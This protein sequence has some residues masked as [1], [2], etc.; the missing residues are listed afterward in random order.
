MSAPSR[1]GAPRS[2]ARTSARP[3]TTAGQRPAARRATTP[4][5]GSVRTSGAR[6]SQARP[7]GP[8]GP[9]RT[10]AQ[11]K[12]RLL[13][14][15]ARGSWTAMLSWRTAVMAGVVMLAFALIMPSLRVYFEQQQ[16]LQQLRTEAADARA[17]V[18]DLNGEV[19]RWQDPAFLVAQARERLAYVFPG[20]TPYRVVDPET[21]DTAEEEPATSVSG[22][23]VA[24]GNTWYGTLW[25]SI[26]VAGNGSEA[27]AETEPDYT[28]PTPHP[29][30][31]Q[32]GSP[33]TSDTSKVNVDFSE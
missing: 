15:K 31:T 25:G 11:A 26:L 10:S 7:G 32:D 14:A 8:S 22:D 9:G 16:Q 27:D 5:T 30:V 17:E 23:G 4:S 18:T 1:P 2:S 33:V 29:K 13:P 21:V 12:P 24:V 19:A 3:G 6:K 20:E 28:D